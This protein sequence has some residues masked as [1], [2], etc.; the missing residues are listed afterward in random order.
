MRIDRSTIPPTDSRIL[1]FAIKE[2]DALGGFHDDALS[3]H[4]ALE[5]IR[6]DREEESQESEHNAH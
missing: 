6:H 1:P 5:S 4:D 2:A 3:V